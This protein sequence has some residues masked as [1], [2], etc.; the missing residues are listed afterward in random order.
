MSRQT[1]EDVEQDFFMALVRADVET[2]RRVLADDF[3]LI[4][5][6]TGSEVPRSALLDVVS[7]GQLRF[8]RIERVEVRVRVYGTAAVVTGRTE[9]VGAYGGQSFGASS[10]YTHVFIDDGAV[11]R[12]VAAQ[13]TQISPQPPA[14]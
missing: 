11:W 8:D 12:M 13:G 5:V 10:R 4:D 1:P 7:G 6:M 9:M 14:A 2:L 3:V